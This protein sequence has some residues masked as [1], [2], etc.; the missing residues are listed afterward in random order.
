MFFKRF[1]YVCVVAM[2]LLASGCGKEGPTGP[3]GPA[4][5]QGLAGPG[6]RTV[7]SGTISAAAN[8]TGQLVSVPQLNLA[9]FPLVAVYVS[10]GTG[11]WIQCNLILYDSSTGGYPL[12]ETAILRTGSITLF[13]TSVGNEYRIVIV[14]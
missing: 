9:N 2:C 11:D 4:G 5:P 1:M 7:L 3:Q 13:S 8:S 14:T 6:T 10:D 12:F